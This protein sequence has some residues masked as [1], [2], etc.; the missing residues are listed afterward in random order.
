VILRAEAGHEP[1]SFFWTSGSEARAFSVKQ[2]N[3]NQVT[4]SGVKIAGTVRQESAAGD[5]FERY[6]QGSEENS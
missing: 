2:S 4:P 1:G 6:H 5:Y 3:V